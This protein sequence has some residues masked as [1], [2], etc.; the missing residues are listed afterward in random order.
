MASVHLLEE[1]ADRYGVEQVISEYLKG[2]LNAINYLPGTILCHLDAVLRHHPDVCFTSNHHRMILTL[3]DAVAAK[4]MALEI[5]T[6]GYRHRAE[7]YPAGPVVLAA[8]HRGIKL[9][10][11][12]DAHRP[13]QVGRNF[14]RLPEFI[15]HATRA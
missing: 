8:L 15:A 14:D 2:L 3:L 6:S 11:S 9:C 5:N 4:G 1:A 13:E 7:P 12:S 10:A